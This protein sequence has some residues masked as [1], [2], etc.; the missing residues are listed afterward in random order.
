[1]RTA[2][3][4]SV[5]GFMGAA[6][7]QFIEMNF[8]HRANA[9]PESIVSARRIDLVDASGKLRAQLGFSKEGP[10]GFWLLDEKGTARIAMGLYPDGTSHLGLQDRNGLMIQLMR[11]V[12]AEEAPV[13]IQKNKGQDRLILGL[14]ATLTPFFVSYDKQNKKTVHTGF[15]DGP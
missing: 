15:A 7:F 6:L 9:G 1:M 5:F 12:G 3:L 10:P 2:I 8:L 14:N 4:A 13:L 11:S